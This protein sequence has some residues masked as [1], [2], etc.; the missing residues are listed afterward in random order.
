LPFVL[1]ILFLLS[2]LTLPRRSTTPPPADRRLVSIPD[3]AVRLAV[4]ERE[5]WKLV[6][7]GTLPSLKLG[8]RRLITSDSLD[9]FIAARLDD[10]S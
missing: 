4:G 9:A 8:R 10:A 3:A 6:G 7:N 1:F 2:R 5:V